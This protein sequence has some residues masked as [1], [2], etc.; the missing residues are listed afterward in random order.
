MLRSAL[1]RYE[2]KNHH[3]RFYRCHTVALT[4]DDAST[5]DCCHTELIRSSVFS[6]AADDLIVRMLLNYHGSQTAQKSFSQLFE[7]IH[8]VCKYYIHV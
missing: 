6:L 8:V 7:G 5:T 3:A 4:S 1:Q 2:K